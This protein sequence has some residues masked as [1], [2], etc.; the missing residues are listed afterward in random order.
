MKSG[1][2]TPGTHSHDLYQQGWDDAMEQVNSSRTMVFDGEGRP[3][4]TREGN[5]V[6][7]QAAPPNAE[8][9][10]C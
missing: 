4:V 6:W 9:K 8:W 1:P 2:Y 7:T 3:C 5:A 10:S